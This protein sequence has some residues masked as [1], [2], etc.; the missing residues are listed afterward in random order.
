MEDFEQVVE[1]DLW[2]RHRWTKEQKQ[3]V[4]HFTGNSEQ[5]FNAGKVMEVAQQ[6]GLLD[7][8]TAT[9]LHE[10][11][12]FVTGSRLRELC[13]AEKHLI[14]FAKGHFDDH[15]H[16]TLEHI[17][18]YDMGISVE[19]V[20]ETFI[21][22]RLTEL[23]QQFKELGVIK[24]SYPTLFVRMFARS[25][26][27]EDAFGGKHTT[28]EGIVVKDIIDTILSSFG[29]TRFVDET[30]RKLLVGLTIDEALLDKWPPTDATT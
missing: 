21:W 5:F 12:Q 30:G 7:G 26:H 16:I 10:A 28:Q 22:L 13:E 9:E 25:I 27:K 11:V 1:L 19:S 24:E 20:T 6:N 4:E 18:A 15:P 14:L 2:N 3:F 23:Y 8:M 17:H 29:T